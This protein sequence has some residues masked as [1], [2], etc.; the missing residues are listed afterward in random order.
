MMEG[1]LLLATMMRRY[2]FDVHPGHPIELEPLITLR[3]KHGLMVRVHR[4]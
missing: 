1:Q 2:R 3:P 4:R